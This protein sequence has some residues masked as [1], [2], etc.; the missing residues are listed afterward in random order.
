MSN[1]LA[2]ISEEESGINLSQI[3]QL[4]DQ[5]QHKTEEQTKVIKAVNINQNNNSKNQNFHKKS[6]ENI[7]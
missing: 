5:K 6:F 7:R 4:F 2:M 1:V 3:M